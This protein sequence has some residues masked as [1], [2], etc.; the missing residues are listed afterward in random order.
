[1]RF[2]CLWFKRINPFKKKDTHLSLFAERRKLGDQKMTMDPALYER[3]LQD[4]DKRYNALPKPE[5]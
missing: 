2:I 3:K 4:L 5:D 1:M